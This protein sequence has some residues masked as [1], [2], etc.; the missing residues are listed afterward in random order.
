MT[1]TSKIK[2]PLLC[3]ECTRIMFP[4]DTLVICLTMVRSLLLITSLL[5]SLVARSW[6]TSELG[7]VDTQSLRLWAEG[8]SVCI[9]VD[10]V[11]RV[12]HSCWELEKQE[13][14]VLWVELH[15][16]RRCV[17]VLIPQHLWMHLIWKC[18]L[19]RCSQAS[20]EVIR[21]API[22]YDCCPSQRGGILGHAQERRTPCNRR[23]QRAKGCSREPREPRT[24]GN[25]SESGKRQVKML[26]SRFQ[27]EP[28]PADTLTSD[29]SL[30][31]GEMREISL[32]FRAMWCVILV[33]AA[34]GNGY[35]QSGKLPMIP[36]Q[37]MAED[38]PEHN[39]CESP[40]LVHCPGLYSSETSQLSCM[41]VCFLTSCFCSGFL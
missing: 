34:L 8:A 36:G 32:L 27:K 33:S 16:L 5:G 41:Q 20:D 38:T 30:Q 25:P 10:W 21:V 15:P 24:A 7:T 13:R 3:Q 14:R 6:L 12:P 35:R 4:K 1:L 37:V 18:G 17:K 2:Q 19:C 9:L 11:H 28:D 22:Q 31:N 23:R 26:P 29:F 39:S 40:D